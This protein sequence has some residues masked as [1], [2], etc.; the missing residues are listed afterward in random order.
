MAKKLLL[1]IG[2]YLLS[3]SL[4]ILFERL[5]LYCYYYAF[6]K[7]YKSC[8]CCLMNYHKS[9]SFP[10]NYHL[11][12]ELDPVNFSSVDYESRDGEELREAPLL[13]AFSLTYREIPPYF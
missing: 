7:V 6:R 5:S 10:C 1:D 13:Q 4:V 9:F 2:V 12:Q 8:V 3:K 11:G